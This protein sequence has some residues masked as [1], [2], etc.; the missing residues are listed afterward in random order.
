ML[1]I[2]QKFIWENIYNVFSF[3]F[4]WYGR[5]LKQ[6][7]WIFGNSLKKADDLL[8]VWLWM[9]HLFTP[10]YGQRDIQGRIISFFMRLIQLI[11]RMFAFIFWF[12]FVFILFIL[13]LIILPIIF[14]GIITSFLLL[15]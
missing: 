15:L 5:G 7:F 14:Y 2:L 6:M 8:G 9:S 3:P 1:L 4:W 10:M 12:F 11:A 13:W